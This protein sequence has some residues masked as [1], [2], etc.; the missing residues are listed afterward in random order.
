MTTR[1]NVI[2]DCD[3]GHDDAIS[4]ILAAFSE[5]IN[6][7]AITTVAGNVEV[8]KTTLNAQRICDL[9]QLNDIPLAMGAERPLVKQSEIA[10]E[11]HGD[12]GLD[13]PHF[14]DAPVKK[15]E[16]I[17]AADLIIET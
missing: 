17:H 4:I 9:L 1:T 15:V 8:E 11:I 7:E 13:G 14:P 5:K 16:E 12:S 2:L 10:G 6:I 3:P